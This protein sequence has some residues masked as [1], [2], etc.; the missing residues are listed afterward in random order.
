MEMMTIEDSDVCNEMQTIALGKEKSHYPG[1]RPM[2]VPQAKESSRRGRKLAAA[3]AA[4]VVARAQGI[5]T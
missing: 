3:V 5:E 1:H 2:S 4:A